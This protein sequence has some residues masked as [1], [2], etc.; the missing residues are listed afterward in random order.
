MVIQKPRSPYHNTYKIA[1]TVKNRNACLETPL[2]TFPHAKPNPSYGISVVTHIKDSYLLFEGK[3]RHPKPV[4]YQKL[5]CIR[6]SLLPNPAFE[7]FIPTIHS[8]SAL[9]SK[10]I[11]NHT[12]TSLVSIQIEYHNSKLIDSLLGEL[13]KM[14]L[15]KLTTLIQDIRKKEFWPLIKIDI[16]HINDFEIENWQYILIILKFDSSLEKADEYL[17]IFYNKLD[18]FIAA[19]SEEEQN[20]LQRIIYFDIQTAVP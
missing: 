20:I 3:K 15:G 6:K 12:K 18:T 2:P 10:I 1:C 5:L 17:H 19:L 8:K 4:A 11:D 14:V 16:Y 13:G 7:E 9:S